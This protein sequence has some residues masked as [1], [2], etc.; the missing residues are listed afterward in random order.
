VDSEILKGGE[1]NVSALSSFIANA[2]NQLYAFYTGK[3]G[4]LQ[5]KSESIDGG[6]A[7]TPPPLLGIPMR[8]LIP[9]LTL[10]FA[11]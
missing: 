5:K 11:I 4:L 9:T 7:A 3:G 10:H 1:D 2:H 6:G 8:I